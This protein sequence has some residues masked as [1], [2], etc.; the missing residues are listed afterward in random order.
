V[1][2]VT[3]VTCALVNSGYEVK[4][5]LMRGALRA[6]RGCRPTDVIPA[7]DSLTSPALSQWRRVELASWVA[8]SLRLGRRAVV[9]GCIHRFR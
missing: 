6:A 7:S 2:L 5:P 3:V 4:V 9:D 1:P 8:V